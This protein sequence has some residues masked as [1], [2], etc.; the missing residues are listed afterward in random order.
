MATIYLTEQEFLERHPDYTRCIDVY[1][2]CPLGGNCATCMYMRSGLDD[3]DTKYS[4][5]ATYCAYI[6]KEEES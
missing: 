5:S 6:C 3:P 1:K 4:W 2:S